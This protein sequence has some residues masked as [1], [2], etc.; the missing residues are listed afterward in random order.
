MRTFVRD[1]L[2]I[3]CVSSSTSV[4]TLSLTLQTLKTSKIKLGLTNN[5]SFWFSTLLSIG[6][7]ALNFGFHL[8]VSN[9]T[10]F[11]VSSSGR[12]WWLWVGQWWWCGIVFCWRKGRRVEGERERVVFC[13]QH[14]Q[15]WVGRRWWCIG[16]DFRWRRKK[17]REERK[18]NW[19]L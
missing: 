7:S 10:S 4:H 18:D 1:L 12:W 11:I 16:G 19:F 14:S 2:T 3:W 13:W 17:M 9:N 8:G 5:F 6:F 15:Q